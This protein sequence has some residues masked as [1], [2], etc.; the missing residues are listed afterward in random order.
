MWIFTKDGFYSVV[1][2]KT[3]EGMLVVRARCKD[4]LERFLKK[5]NPVNS[6]YIETGTG[7]DYEYRVFVRRE[8][9][10]DYLVMACSE[11]NYHNFKGMIEETNVDKP[12]VL[13]SRLDAM[14]AVWVAMMQFQ[15]TVM[16]I[17]KK[18]KN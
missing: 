6:A 18:G 5:V 14:Y 7:T 12:S 4:D 15:K 9:W 2:K 16:Q 3:N 10:E 17:I 13:E 8:V 11:I 1:E